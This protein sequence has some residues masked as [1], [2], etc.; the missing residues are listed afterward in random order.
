MAMPSARRHFARMLA[1]QVGLA[2]EQLTT[3]CKG[4]LLHDIGKISVPDAILDKPGPLTEDEF[5]I[6]RQ[7]PVL[8]AHIVEPLRSVRPSFP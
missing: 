2:D 1:V 8:G 5:R 4:A 7:H 3:L 6:I